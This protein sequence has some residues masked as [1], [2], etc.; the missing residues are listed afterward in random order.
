MNAQTLEIKGG[1]IV[2][3]PERAYLKLLERAGES[4]SGNTDEQ[5]LPPCGYAPAMSATGR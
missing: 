1:R 3:L 5:R 2:Q 4:V